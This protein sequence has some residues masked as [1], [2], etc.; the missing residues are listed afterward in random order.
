MRREKGLDGT[1]R[2]EVKQRKEVN[3]GLKNYSFTI[4]SLCNITRCFPLS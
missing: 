3:T 4:P 1:G 2:Q